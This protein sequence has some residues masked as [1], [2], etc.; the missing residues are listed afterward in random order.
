MRENGL[1]AVKFSMENSRDGHA[2]PAPE[3]VKGGRDQW[4]RWIDALR[5]YQLDGLLV[6]FMDVG[7]PFAFLSAQLMY[8]TSPF[9]GTGLEQV[10]KMLESDEES[11]AFAQLLAGRA[12][13]ETRAR[14]GP[15]G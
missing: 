14:G 6:W 13:T 3:G 5:K 10:G 2:T 8:M 4:P 1:P 15:A 7:R 12:E 11:Q 9:L